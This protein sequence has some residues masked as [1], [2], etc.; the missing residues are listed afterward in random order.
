MAAKAPSG[1]VM[2]A[3]ADV[4]EVGLDPLLFKLLL[5]PLEVL[6]PAPGFA[7]GRFPKKNQM[8]K[9]VPAFQLFFAQIAVFNRTCN[10]N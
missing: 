3:A 8:Q 1:F 2:L 7:L 9:C 5:L 10:I 6:D 4:L